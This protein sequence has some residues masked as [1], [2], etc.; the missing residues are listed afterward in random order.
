MNCSQCGRDTYFTD[1]Y[2][3]LTTPQAQYS[4]CGRDCVSAWLGPDRPLLRRVEEAKNRAPSPQH[5]VVGVPKWRCAHG[6]SDTPC[7]VCSLNAQVFSN[8]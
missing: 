8:G 2:W 6:E 7:W 1:T 4:F 5:V 3:V